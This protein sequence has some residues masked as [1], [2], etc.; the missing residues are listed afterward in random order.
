MTHAFDTTEKLL[1]ACRGGDRRAQEVFYRKY[2]PQL[3]P[4]CRRLLGSREA[5]VACLNQGMLRIFQ[6]LS[7]YREDGRLDAWLATIVRRTALNQIRDEGRAQRRFLARD[8]R[9]PHAVP[10][11]GLDTLAVADILKLLDALADH[12]RV[13]FSL[14]VFEGLTHPEIATE[15][16]ITAE[17]SR[18]RLNQ[19]R[20]LLRVSYASTHQ[21]KT[22][23]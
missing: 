9:W 15:L 23:S 20:K 4:I 3:L 11:E 1:A 22:S 7:D 19:A 18:W 2:F 8:F 17:A 13:V 10:N 12:L 6:S 21:V 16:G 14:Y 5:A